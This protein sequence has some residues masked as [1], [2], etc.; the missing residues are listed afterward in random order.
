MKESINNFSLSELQERIRESLIDKLPEE[1]WV[2]AEVSELKINYSGHYYLELTETSSHDNNVIARIRAIIWNRQARLLIPYFKTTAGHD[3]AEGLRIMV[4]VKIEYHSLYG[5]SLII[6]DIDPKFTIG[7]LALK[8]REIIN[9]LR[10]DGVIEMNKLLSLPLLP[11]NIAVISSEKAA[12]YQDF[13]DHLINNPYGYTY[14]ADLFHAA[15]QGYETS[16]S[17][18]SA[19]DRINAGPVNYDVVVIVRGGGSQTDL[20]WFDNYELGY[21]IT[22]FPIPVIT[23]IGHDKDLSVTDIVANRNCKTPTAAADLIIE[24]TASVENHLLSI[25]DSIIDNTERIL[26]SNRTKIETFSLKLMPVARNEIVKKSNLLKTRSMVLENR[27]KLLL[28]SKEQ[29]ILSKAGHLINNLKFYINIKQGLLSDKLIKLQTEPGR[30]LYD[31]NLKIKQIGKLIHHLSPENVL[32]RGYSITLKDN[33][34]VKGIKGLNKGEKVT[35][36]LYDG[37]LS[38]EIFEISK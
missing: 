36:I 16:L 14:E 1:Y 24:T 10:S 33:R 6:L 34:A 32:K 28:R 3:L 17:I 26:K 23:G 35:T 5:L 19:F 12:G 13:S 38:S 37:K 9:R 8:K 7:D 31:K 11:K 22:Q 29:E 21:F 20:N 4:K 18:I 25:K 2:R 30:N 27:V 15:M